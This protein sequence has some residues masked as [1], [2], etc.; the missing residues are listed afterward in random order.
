MSEQIKTRATMA[1]AQAAWEAHPQPTLR[2]VMRAMDDAGLTINL[3]TLQR[4]KK[5][6]FVPKEDS[7]SR[8]NLNAP[9]APMP[10]ERKPK[11]KLT[12][13]QSAAA[14]VEVAK[15]TKAAESKTLTRLE[16][17]EQEEV[18][19]A[20]ERETLLKEPNLTKLSDTAKREC[21][22]ASIALARQITRRAAV[23]VEIC[24]EIAAKALDVLME[25]TRS[26]TIVLP[27]A[28][29]QSGQNGDGAKVVE[30]RAIES[31]S[32]VALEQFRARRR[33]GVP[34]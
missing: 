18:A 16:V 15:A 6:S 31:A 4:W 7:R 22:I 26:T 12:A 30:G 33:T 2:N 25:A 10:R 21:L 23:L 11:V 34:A 24:P 28:P 5:A 27:D 14:S 17:I 3:A 19:M 8:G 1:Q 32:A 29:D 13:E 20:A 9:R